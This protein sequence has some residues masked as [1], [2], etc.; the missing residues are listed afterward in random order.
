[1][2]TS[3][4]SDSGMVNT[5][6]PPPD[7]R[8]GGELVP[9]GAQ[10]LAPYTGPIWQGG[11]AP[12][13]EMLSSGPDPMS[14]LRAFKRRW[15]LATGLGMLAAM[16]A[17]LAAWFLVPERGEVVAYVLVARHPDAVMDKDRIPDGNEF[18]TFK[19][20]VIQQIRNK[21]LLIRALRDPQISQ[22]PMVKAQKDQVG[23][24]EDEL[25]L[26]YPDDAEILRI[27][28]RGEDVDQVVK[29]V[30]AVV[31]AFFKV[32][33]EEKFRLRD[34][35]EKDLEQL[36]RE[37]NEELFQKRESVKKLAEAIG[38]LDSTTAVMRHSELQSNVAS[39]SNALLQAKQ[40]KLTAEIE[41]LRLENEIKLAKDPSTI[42]A[43]AEE[44][45][46]KD[47]QIKDLEKELADWDKTIAI[48]R[49]TANGE[50][51]SVK[52]YKT[53]QKGVAEQLEERR[54][55]LLKDYEE[56]HS[57][58]KVRELESKLE[59]VE[60]SIRRADEQI[61]ELK[62]QIEEDQARLSQ[63]GGDSVQID[64]NKQEIL[65]L[66]QFTSEVTKKLEE[67]RTEKR[68]PSRIQRYGDAI[69][70]NDMGS[71]RKLAMVAFSGFAAFT[72]IGLAVS[73]IE[74]QARRI[75]SSTQLIDG[76]GMRVVGALPSIA[77]PGRKA[78]AS[79][80]GDLNGVL[81]E[82]ID[83]VR[84]N[85]IHSSASESTRVVMVT[86]ALDREGK[87]TVASQ[88]AASLARC[89][90]RTLLVD[91]DLRRPTAHRLFE[92]PLEPGVCEVLRGEAEIDDVIRPT[93]VAGLWMI[94]AGQY[95]LESI[96]A[97][98]RQGAGD[99]FDVLRNRFDFVI[100]DSAPVLS[101]AD[102]SMLGQHVDAAILCVMRDVS[103]AA[104][105]YDASE[106]LRSVGIHVLGAVINGERTAAT[107][108]AYAA[109]R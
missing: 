93:R 35:K 107:Y 49:K 109:R 54:S 41:K 58:Q 9:V 22:L 62:E 30:N 5:I 102:A 101:I 19:A 46:K 4:N 50:S 91:G 36:H 98:S 7:E 1:M 61:S 25:M 86:S 27:R 100:V 40:Q 43:L 57:G 18:I 6:A 53:Q 55:K 24:L 83:T 65:T 64:H 75:S 42:Q 97:L 87:T 84:T 14:L 45:I 12:R 21:S 39:K 73:F 103:Q 88:L 105:V 33:V 79:A 31:D 108:R 66:N 29:I 95:D 69:A 20:T 16:A 17:A 2:A 28:M 47:E 67:L 10:S 51:S 81:L 90:R 77:R 82:S 60:E 59:V 26:D 96:Q 92:L 23:W 37:K 38:A 48:A 78:L 11:I 76:L 80:K 68:A 85:L 34:K 94:P 15:M 52:R 72:L 56:L 32:V 74:F 99:A 44:E 13:P 63:L 71:M 8:R 89:G 70:P 3:R 104:K 106:Q